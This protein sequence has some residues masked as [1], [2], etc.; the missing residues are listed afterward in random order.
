MIW[1]RIVGSL[2]SYFDVTVVFRRVWFDN[3]ALYR[4]VR[5]S[6]NQRAVHPAIGNKRKASYISAS[7]AAVRNGAGSFKIYGRGTTD[8]R[9]RECIRVD[10]ASSAND[11]SGRIDGK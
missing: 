8:F 3:E 11:E 2:L 7:I 10:E 9:V 4:S 1:E 6:N 5:E